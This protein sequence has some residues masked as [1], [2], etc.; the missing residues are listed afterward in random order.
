MER[1]WKKDKRKP[2]PVGK[3]WQK[4]QRI[5]EDTNQKITSRRSNGRFKICCQR[6]RDKMMARRYYSHCDLHDRYKINWKKQT[7]KEAAN[8]LRKGDHNEMAVYYWRGIANH[9]W[10]VE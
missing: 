2:F 9:N 10:I 8:Q 5:C 4:M 1:E 3:T 7:K 6:G